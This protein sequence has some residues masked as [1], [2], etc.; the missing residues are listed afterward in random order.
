MAVKSVVLDVEVKDESFNKFAESFKKYQKALA[1]TPKAWA[2]VGEHATST[3]ITFEKLVA[4][5]LAQAEF[6]HVLSEKQEVVTKHV[7]HQESAW[8]GIARSTKTVATNILDATRSLLRWAEIGGVVSGLLGLGGL[9]GMERLALAA[10]AQRRGAL[11]MGVS[12][13]EQRSFGVNFGRVVNPDQFLGG[14]NEA[15]HDVTKRSSLYAAG[16]GEGSIKGK[17]TAQ[18]AAALI[19]ALKRLADQ[20]PE[21]MM[22][23]VL[24]ARQLDQF[25]SLED[26][27]RL[28]NTPGAEIAQYGKDYQRDIGSLNLTKGQQKAWQDFQVQLTRAGEQ[29]EATFIRGLTP[30]TPA[31]T[32]LSSEFSHFIQVLLDSPLIKQWIQQFGDALHWFADQIDT[33]EFK[34]GVEAFASGVVKIAKAIAQAIQWIAGPSTGPAPVPNNLRSPWIPG[35]KEAVW[36]PGSMSSG[37]GASWLARNDMAHQL[38]MGLTDA[39]WAAESSRGAQAEDSSAGAQGPFQFMPGTW[40]Q[41][42]RG[43]VHNTQD[44][45]AAMGRYYQYLLP[46]YNGDLAKAAAGYNWGPGNL[47]GAIRKYGDNWKAH[48]PRETQNYVDKIMRM[49]SKSASAQGRQQVDINVYN[50]TGGSAVVAASQVRGTWL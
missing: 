6:A 13:G 28:R 46:H 10:S 25:I 29:I 3:G 45:A 17:N 50:N 12:P 32:K 35:P 11:G 34:A 2:E 9:F 48:A 8:R 43:D 27:Q 47:D 49:V 33:P 26:F 15:L 20:T 42:G 19:P 22:A 23:Q 44:A 14:V 16:L 37:A 7:E 39:T 40:A 38:P 36:R 41:Y 18:V 4:A 5:L 31:L 24:K 30:L 21:P 1:E